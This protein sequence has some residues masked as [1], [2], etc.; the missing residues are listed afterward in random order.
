MFWGGLLLGIMLGGFV[1]M[2]VI[3]V[4][5]ASKDQDEEDAK[6]YEVAENN[7]R[8]YY[9][10]PFN[11]IKLDGFKTTLDVVIKGDIDFYKR[12]YD[13]NKNPYYL[14]RLEECRFLLN[15]VEGKKENETSKS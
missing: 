1:G 4:I 12:M 6:N 14:G 15:M 7:L 9:T 2:M 8:K 11:D 3:A 10:R 13:I 5:V